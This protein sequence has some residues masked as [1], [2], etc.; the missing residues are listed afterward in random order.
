MPCTICDGPTSR[1]RGRFCREC[2]LTKIIN[3]GFQ[4]SRYSG[5]WRYHCADCSSP[6]SPG[7]SLC[8]QCVKNHKSGPLNGRWGT[9]TS[10]DP[11][12]GRRR[13]RRRKP[14]GQCERCATAKA[15]DVHHVDD[16]PLNNEPGNLLA[17]C[18]RCHMTLD[19]RLAR[20]KPDGGFAA[21]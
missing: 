7:A 11:E 19:G 20:R 18:R 4:T 9:F 2:Y 17:L 21:R 10:T 1:N 5:A 6:V 14:L 15:T 8:A 16:D 13:A 3:E 12:Q